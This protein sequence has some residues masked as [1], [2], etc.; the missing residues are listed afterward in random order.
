MKPWCNGRRIVN[1]Y[2][3]TEITVF[4]SWYL[5][6][7]TEQS[8]VPIGYPIWNTQL[9]VLDG[10]LEPVPVGVS[11]E[12][13]IGGVGLARGYLGRP[14]LTAER[15]VPDPFGSAGGRLYRTGDRVCRRADGALEFLGR[16]DHQVKLRGY[17]IETGEIEAALTSHPS[18]GQAAVLLR[19][20]G[21]GEGRLVAYVVGDASAGDLRAHL[22]QTL[23]DYMVPAAFVTLSAL[24]LTRTESL[25]ARRCQ[26]LMTAD[27]CVRL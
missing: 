2:G 5:V 1:A 21:P 22:Q 16:Y 7:A 13:Y 26:N 18:V 6:N 25:T 24:P 8:S 23:P 20:D 10:G 3:P 14:D 17:R 4:A 11:G 12:L 27:W 9:Y 15:F 19:A